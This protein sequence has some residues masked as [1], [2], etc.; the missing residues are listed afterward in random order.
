MCGNLPR[1]I[2]RRS[3]SAR[4]SRTARCR[5]FRAL[6]ALLTA[7]AVTSC[8]APSGSSAG[9]GRTGGGPAGNLSSASA[10]G[11]APEPAGT[12]AALPGVP[13]AP[14]P[15]IAPVTRGAG[16]SSEESLHWVGYTFAASNVSGVRAEWTEPEVRGRAGAE[17]F[18]W[19]GVGGWNQAISNIVQD[20]TF[21]YFPRSGGMNEGIWYERVPSAQKAVFPLVGASPG[22]HI[23]ASVTRLSSA[24]SK[25]R[26]SVN[27][28]SSGSSF[29]TS[30]RFHSL[31]AYPS[32]VVEDPNS[33]TPG[34]VGPFYPFPR[35]KT[36]TFS[37]IQVRVKGT[38]AAAATLPGVRIDMVR[39]GR[40]L[41]T[42]GPLSNRSSFSARQR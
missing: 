12:P 41:A 21:V 2:A 34:P 14:F 39:D 25:W 13:S 28:V 17:E 32:F 33:G 8:S 29:A 23:Y 31:G 24:S 37:N 11:S 42:A 22:D 16:W 1:R 15:Q 19:I 38:W 30:L 4:H 27:D 10:S 6:A 3:R 20:G 40:V 9:A 18:V 7:A 26:I 35:W 36:V 5:R